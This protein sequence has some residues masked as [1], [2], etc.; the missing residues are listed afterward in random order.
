LKAVSLFDGISCGRL[1]LER[2]EYAVSSYAAFEIDKFARAI[3]RY[4]YPDIKQCGDVFDADFN[5]FAGADLVIGGSP[6]AFWSVS[7]ARREISKDGQGWRLFMRFAEAVRQIKPRFFLYE[8]VATMHRDIRSYISGE[9]AC[10][11]ILI[12]SSLVSAQ[13]RKRLYW[14]NISG[15][16]QPEDAG[17]LLKDILETGLAAR[18][19]SYCIDACYAKG[20]GK[21]RLDIQDGRRQL[22]YEPVIAPRDHEKCFAELKRRKTKRFNAHSLIEAGGDVPPIP[23]PVCVG[24]TGSD[25]QG[26]R[27]YS[28]H[29][30]TVSL[31]ALGGGRGGRVGLYKVDLPDGGYTVRQL[32]NT[33]AERCQTLPDGYTALGIDDRGKTVKIS[34]TQ[35]Y[36]CIGNGWTVNVIAHILRH[37]GNLES[38]ES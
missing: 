5:Q 35:R 8:N 10:E 11:P 16:T 12:N 20:I 15:V 3:S 28:V 18:E 19:K 17:I 34:K 25:S 2:A 1:A 22:V 37:M 4:N 32:T 24:F 36:K 6:C 7:K 38:E 13:Q 9:L 21:K 14:T 26:C 23:F 27:V 33:E 30:K 31:M 29:G